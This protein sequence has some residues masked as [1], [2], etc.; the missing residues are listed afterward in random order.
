MHG[1][2]RKFSGLRCFT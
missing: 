2:T 1:V